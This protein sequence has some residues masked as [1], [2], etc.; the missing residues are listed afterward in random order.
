M[1]LELSELATYGIAYLSLLFGAAWLTDQGWIPR[2]ITSHPLV[3][4][5]ALGVYA[6][7]WAFYGAVGMAHQYGFVFLAYYLGICGAFLLAPVLLSP[8]L[9]ITRDYQLG[10]LADLFAFRFRSSAAGALTTFMMLLAM[11]PLVAMQIQAVADSIH[12]LAREGSPEQLAFGFCI[13]ITLFTMA[14][15]TRRIS[16]REKHHGLVFAIA[17]E[18]VVK[19]VALLVLGGVI[20]FQIFG[21]PQELQEWLLQNREALSSLRMSLDDGP[22][23]TMLLIFF[24]AAIVMPDM[25]HMTFTENQNTRSLN[26]ASWGLPLYL[27]LMSLPVPLI[28]WG[29][30]MLPAAT[31]PEYYALGIGLELQSPLLTLLV[32]IGAMSASSGVII[33]TTLALSAM[34]VNH[35]ILPVY[36]PPSSINI[37]RW[38]SWTK[39]ALI[40]TMI[41]AAYGFYRMLEAELDLATIAVVSFVA[42]LQFLPGVLSTI[43]WTHANRRGFLS[44]LIAGSLVWFITMLIPLVL[45]D[46]VFTI[47]GWTFELQETNWHGSALISLSV[48]ILV[49]VVVS[50]LSESSPE[51]KNAANSCS[52]QMLGRPSRRSLLA[53]SPR[54]FQERLSRPLGAYTAQREVFQ[55]LKDLNMPLD[56]KRPYALRRL[57]D[58]IEANLSGLMGPSVSRDIINRYLPYGHDNAGVADINYVES[59][60]E[61][62][63]YRLT[64]LAAELDTLR[65][66]HRQTLQNLPM[67]ICS[68]GV[69]G[70][71]MM[72]NNAMTD[73]TGIASSA[74]VGSR[75]SSLPEPWRDLLVGFVSEKGEPRDRR[76]I[77]IDGQPRTLNIHK[78]HL[79]SAGGT[80]LMIED[81]TDSF[82]LEQKLIHSE[83]LASIGQLAAGVAHEIGNPVTGVDCLAQEL[84]SFAQDDDT[85]EIAEQILEQTKRIAKIL[86]SL[87]NFAH[88]GQSSDELSVESVSLSRCTSEASSLLELNK[89]N[90]GIR[91]INNCGPDDF[92]IGDGQKITQILIN[93]LSNARDASPDN[94]IITINTSASEHTIT[95]DVTDQGCGISEDNQKRLFEPFFT[96]KEAGKGTGL[97]MALV[98]SIV[99]EHFGT[100]V[101]HSPVNKEKG[102]G[103][104]ISVSLPRHLAELDTEVKTPQDAIELV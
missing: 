85:K 25:F 39:R 3:Y 6:S 82:L 18:S 78:A 4:T 46:D 101:V 58:R 30:L 32:Y 10:S 16:S 81:Q 28:L 52:I 70:E 103:T 21:G 41:L 12:I 40:A 74:T 63:Q 102:T 13:I 38:L 27:L 61:E 96:T 49:L 83:R 1:T 51:E 47:F 99:E 97:G 95:L 14:F 31:T 29:G 80:V 89:Q 42:C 60:V 94:S 48:N 26:S 71:I 72:W 37:Y 98:Y 62:Y 5:L 67:A 43:Y 75:L 86:H 2:K 79:G 44:G 68:L 20:L 54:E 91:F 66:Y 84:R 22:W 64:G 36:Q 53:S 90:R 34:V 57:R 92:I 33:V 73:V 56:E 65:R 87:I 15:G 100:I 24:A 23:R 50:L 88:K 93:L 19:V 55:A 8:I 35:L 11:L 7:A 9:R 104:R 45:V 17:I 59:Q 77:I 69:D 76:Q